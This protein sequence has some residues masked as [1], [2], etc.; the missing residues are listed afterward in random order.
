MENDFAQLDAIMKR[1]PDLKS[2]YEGALAQTLLIS[3]RIPQA[4]MLIEDIVKRTEPDHLQLYQAYTQASVLVAE[5]KYTE[6]LALS[7]D[8]K[9][10]LEALPRDLSSNLFTFNLIRL[11]LLYQQL[12]QPN[13]ELQIWGELLSK[14][15]NMAALLSIGEILRIGEASFSQYIEERKKEIVSAIRADL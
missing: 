12:N 14:T 5:K 10:K 2:K 4:K 15:E 7:N 6:A 8:L 13:E 11:A 3:D 9:L 1:H